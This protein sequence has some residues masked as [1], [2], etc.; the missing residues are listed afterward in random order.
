M[1]ALCLT[2]VD[3]PN[4][5]NP[6]NLT[7]GLCSASVVSYMKIWKPPKHPITLLKCC[8]S[9][10]L[11]KYSH[12]NMSLKIHSFPNAPFPTYPS[13]AK[14]KHLPFTCPSGSLYC[15]TLS[16]PHHVKTSCANL[17]QS[18]LIKINERTDM[19]GL[20]G[21]AIGPFHRAGP[22]DLLIPGDHPLFGFYIENPLELYVFILLISPS[23]VFCI[24]Q[25]KWE[26]NLSSLTVL[27]HVQRVDRLYNILIWCYHVHA[28]VWCGCPCQHV[29]AM[30]HIWRSEDNFS[31]EGS[32]L[33]SRDQTQ[34]SQSLLSHL[35]CPSLV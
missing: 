15:C 26:N 34:D 28:Y 20:E 31:G 17:G 13:K 9:C 14:W 21:W 6:G 30:T 7:S 29:C 22:W 27:P 1:A 18:L 12:L 23:L 5:W 3:V 2:A 16:I 33:S 4:Y 35:S 11:H 10:G 19:W 25:P 32:S 8:Y 24:L